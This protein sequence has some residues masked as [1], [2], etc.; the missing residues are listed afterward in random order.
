MG[1]LLPLQAAH[2]H[3]LGVHDQPPEPAR[4]LPMMKAAR[5]F[6]A[7]VLLPNDEHTGP[8]NSTR[9][10]TPWFSPQT[11]KQRACE[12]AKKG[13]P[14]RPRGR[15]RAASA[16]RV[17]T[18][19]LD[20]WGWTMT[21]TRMDGRGTSRM[22]YPHALNR[23]DVGWETAETDANQRHSQT[24]SQPPAT[25][26][27][28]PPPR[29]QK[30]ALE[31]GNPN[32][33]METKLWSGP[34]QRDLQ[35]PGD[36]NSVSDLAGLPGFTPHIRSS[37]HPHTL[38]PIFWCCTDGEGGNPQI[39]PCRPPPFLPP[40]KKKKPSSGAY[41]TSHPPTHRVPPHRKKGCGIARQ[42]TDKGGWGALEP[43]SHLFPAW[44]GCSHVQEPVWWVLAE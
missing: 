11:R 8:H 15:V 32:A 23:H 20:G 40:L 12:I 43:R 26:E 28:P 42:Q 39:G 18:R 10:Q 4:P 34:W 6:A 41:R 3:A 35:R 1:G 7:A 24:A 13:S 2:L 36:G 44:R 29:Q 37:I 33:T 25:I 31:K 17:V 9:Q 38:E 27:R 21:R 30:K 14:S 22:G 5:P 16:P 19:H